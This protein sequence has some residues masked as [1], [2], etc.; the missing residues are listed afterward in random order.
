MCNLLDS[1][2][3]HCGLFLL[4]LQLGQPGVSFILYGDVCGH[5]NHLPVYCPALG[6]RFLGGVGGRRCFC[7]VDIWGLDKCRRRFHAGQSWG[8]SISGDYCGVYLSHYHQCKHL[9]G[10][11]SEKNSRIANRLKPCRSLCDNDLMLL[12]LGITP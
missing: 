12:K 7:H 6:S 9:A 11:L 5:G 4:G 1:R 3:D 10:L 2:V 8:S